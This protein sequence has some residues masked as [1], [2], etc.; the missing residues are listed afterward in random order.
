MPPEQKPMKVLH[1]LNR[2]RHGG[3]ADNVWDQTIAVSRERGLDVQVFSRDSRDLPDTLAG[4]FK[5]FSSGIYARESVR[6]F[7]QILHEF[8]PDLVHANELYPL[9]SYWILPVCK[10]AGI[11]VVY[12]CY[13]Y[14][15]T[16]PVATHFSDGRVCR[17]CP[18]S[19]EHWAV[20]KN[21]RDSHA[22]SVSYALRSAV[23]RKFDL[24]TENVDHFIV[25]SEF[26]RQWLSSEVGVDDS[27]ITTVPCAVPLPSE[28][29]DPAE[30]EYIAFAGRFSPE[31][32]A[33]ILIEAARRL[34]L[35]LK[36]AGFEADHPAIRPGDPIECVLPGTREELAQFYRGARMVV[37]PSTWCETFGL[38]VAEAMSHGVP[39]VATRLGALQNTVDEDVTGLLFELGDIQDLMDKISRLW[40]SPSLCRQLGAAGR[41]KV[42][43]E[44]TLDAHFDQTMRAYRSVVG[45]VEPG[46]V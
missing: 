42:R 34:G 36:L 30:G 18:E 43:T 19:G 20:L 44:F 33:D 32:G 25:P 10:K 7:E 29:V 38:V 28:A 26:S 12:Y 23:T 24:V 35:P 9:I 39:V 27:R 15:L 13:D 2:H 17:R 16:C 22:E 8:E 37:A 1:A 14:R 31:K 41:E 4:R 5:A 11:P 6:Q 46:P 3:G 40:E 45:R 21:C